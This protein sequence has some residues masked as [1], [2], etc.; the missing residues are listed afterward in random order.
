MSID[1]KA[2]ASAYRPEVDGLRAIAVLPVLFYHAGFERFSG[3]FVGVDVFF[4]ISGYLITQIILQSINSG[5]FRISHFYERRFRRI[6]PALFLVLVTTVPAALIWLQPSALEDYFEA[7]IA[8]VFFGSNVLFWQQSD[9]FAE[10]ADENPLLHT[11]SLS[12][13][14][15]FYV[16]FPLLLL[17]FW[18]LGWRRMLLGLSVAMLASFALTEWGWRNSSVANFFLLPTR[19]WELLLGAAISVWVV[20]NGKRPNGDSKFASVACWLGLGCIA[21]A[22][23]YYD[24]STPFPSY[25]AL[26]PTLGTALILFFAS[27]LNSLGR[28]LGSAPLVSV[29]LISYSLYL[30]HQPLFSFARLRSLEALLWPDYLALI[31]LSFILAYCSWRFVEGPFRDRQ[32]VSTAALTWVLVVIA[33]L[34]VVIGV[35]GKTGL[36]GPSQ[37]RIEAS[38]IADKAWS[39]RHKAVKSGI[40]HFNTLGPHGELPDF[41]QHWDC[42]GTVFPSGKR[43]LVVGDSHAAD[44]A[45]AL[46][47]N[48]TPV[49]LMSGGGCSI[50]PARMTQ[51]CRVKF[52]FV[53]ENASENSV[54]WILL[55]NRFVFAELTEESMSRVIEYWQKA[56]AKLMVFSGMP[57]YEGFRSVLARAAYRQIDFTDLTIRRDDRIALRSEALLQQVKVTRP[58]I[59]IF[60]TRDAFCNL[61]EACGWIAGDEILLADHDHLSIAGAKLFGRSLKSHLIDTMIIDDSSS[62]AK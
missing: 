52:D 38:L 44:K 17:L 47:Q 42:W 8:I 36:I 20:G 9:Y 35:A 23:F 40:C 2:D 57:V 1:L 34:L 25:F 46:W 21:V 15:Q 22:V 61:T 12:V 49:G 50:D 31:G 58:N 54:G 56:D 53:I 32:R 5:T 3:G 51:D 60:L 24:E 4:V 29:G 28:A 45:L 19:A 13:E 27:P 39:A 6:L 18:K 7:L 16:V 62:E 11:W 55:A 43:V 41:M 30:W 26:L 37:Q 10:N 48:D 14:E 59:E 33:I